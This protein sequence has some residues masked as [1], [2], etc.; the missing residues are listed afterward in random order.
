MSRYHVTKCVVS[1]DNVVIFFP[2]ETL[3]SFDQVLNYSLDFFNNKKIYS[4]N[5]EG[6]N[7]SYIKCVGDETTFIHCCKTTFQEN[8]RDLQMNGGY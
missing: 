6:T 7:E 3:D 2:T 5:K 4:T 8:R 1:E